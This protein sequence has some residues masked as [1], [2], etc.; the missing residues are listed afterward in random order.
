[1]SY[2]PVAP[3]WGINN[4]TVSLRVPAGPPAS[5]HV[6]HRVAGRRRESLPGRGAGARRHAAW[7]SSARIDPGPPGRGQRLRAGGARRTARRTGRPRSNARRA[8]EF[9]ADALGAE[10]RAVYLAIK[11]QEC[12]KFGAL[13]TDRDYEWYLDTA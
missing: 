4:R 9:V 3:T 7:A 1:M 8:S 11:R 13:V 12:E 10:F 6:E 5:R 2:A